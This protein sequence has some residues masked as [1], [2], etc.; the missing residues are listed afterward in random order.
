M[1][2]RL[3]LVGG[4]LCHRVAALPAAGT[5][6]IYG[7]R[8]NP[9]TDTAIS[10]IQADLTRPS[11]LNSLPANITHVVYAPA[12]DARDVASYQ[13]AYPI[14]LTHLLHALQKQSSLQRVVMVG[15]TAVWPS[16]TAA[17][18]DDWVDETTPAQ[19]DN[20]RGEAILKAEQILHAS[21][22]EGGGTVLRL[23]GIYGPGRHRLINAIRAGRITAPEGPGHWSNRIHVDDA[24]SACLHLLQLAKPAPCYIGTDG[25]PRDK[26]TF[27]DQLADLIRVGR[28]IRQPMPPSGK[29]LSNARLCDS[30]WQPQWPDT[31]EYYRSV[32]H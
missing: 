1:T 4:S 11:S 32:A 22:P 26:A 28:P 8:R 3:L 31:I 15:S 27:Y 10:W 25:W 19:P 24:A 21:L 18:A 13:N 9:P 14:G 29:R 17:T 6:K 5:Y 20:F 12:P 7:L 23:G 2:L 30:G 16:A